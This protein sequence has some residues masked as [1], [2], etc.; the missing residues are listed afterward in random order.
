M[1]KVLPFVVVADHNPAA[2]TVDARSDCWKAFR[3]AAKP[4]RSFSRAGFRAD[5]PVLTWNRSAFAPTFPGWQKAARSRV[6][7]G[8]APGRVRM[9]GARSR[10]RPLS[11]CSRSPDLRRSR[12]EPAVSGAQEI[13]GAGASSSRLHSDERRWALLYR[14]LWRLTHGE[15]KAARNRGRS[16][17]G[18][19]L[20]VAISR[21][22]TTFTKCGRSSAFAKF[23]ARRQRGLSPGSNRNIT[24][25]N[26]TPR[27]SSI[28][29]PRCAGRSLRP[30]VALIGM[31]P[32][33]TF[34][35]GRRP[36]GGAPRGRD[37]RTLA[38]LLRQTFSIR[39]A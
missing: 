35:R 14:L 39:R 17:R 36:L 12:P 10:A 32:A 5:R 34:H 21:F 27:F 13:S 1:R 33:L 22:G 25:W 19:R 4:T 15:P 26:T 31:A 37:R 30:I 18:S 23:R 24:S 8:L 6:A 28:A 38:H 11:H 16:R 2:L 20:R 3:P 9:A 7:T 29:S